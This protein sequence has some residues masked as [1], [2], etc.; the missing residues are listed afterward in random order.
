MRSIFGDNYNSFFHVIFGILAAKYPIIVLLYA[1]YQC[2]DVTEKNIRI[3]F[4]E[5][6]IGFFL[7]LYIITEHPSKYFKV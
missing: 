5:F 2:I 3:D 7:G 6:F 4:A 1:L